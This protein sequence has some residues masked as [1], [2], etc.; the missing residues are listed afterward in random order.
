[1]R[2]TAVYFSDRYNVRVSYDVVNFFNVGVE[3]RRKRCTGSYVSQRRC[4][5]Y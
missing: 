2:F 5:K 3:W 4:Y 1:M